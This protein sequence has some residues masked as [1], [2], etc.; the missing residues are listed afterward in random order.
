MARR[1]PRGA[2]EAA[3]ERAVTAVRRAGRLGPEDVALVAA[4]RASA[5]LVDDARVS[6]DP[7]AGWLLEAA[8]RRH[9]ETLRELELT[10]STR[11]VDPG[12]DPL[13]QALRAFTEADR[14]GPDAAPHVG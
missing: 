7:K 9:V 12:D 3:Y 10:P 6:T 2:C 4:G 13:L 8:I 14:S 1:P 11:P 5:R